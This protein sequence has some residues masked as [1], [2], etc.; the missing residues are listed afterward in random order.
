MSPR[1]RSIKFEM[2]ICCGVFL[3]LLFATGRSGVFGLYRPGSILKELNSGG[4]ASFQDLL[5][6]R[7]AQIDVWL[8]LRRIELAQNAEEVATSIGTIRSDEERLVRSS[9]AWSRPSTEVVSLMDEAVEDCVGESRVLQPGVPVF[10]GAIAMRWSW[11]ACRRD[12]RALRASRCARPG[13]RPAVP[14]RRATGRPSSR[15]ARADV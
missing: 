7:A 1:A 12:R 8:Q 11:I 15:A 5:E 13:R 14:S 6:I 2:V 10:K 9:C 4:M 3:L